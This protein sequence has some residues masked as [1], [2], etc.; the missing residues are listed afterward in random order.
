MVTIR[1]LLGDET[2]RQLKAWA[3]RAGISIEDIAAQDLSRWTQNPPEFGGIGE[4]EVSAPN[5]DQ[6][7]A[8]AS[9]R[10]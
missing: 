6:L 10:S 8:R 7:L 2:A 3:L 9:A 4:V 1:L 5:T